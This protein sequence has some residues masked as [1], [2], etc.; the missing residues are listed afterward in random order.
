MVSRR[1]Q[2]V[3]MVVI[4]LVVFGITSM[5]PLEPPLPSPTL[6]Y[7]TPFPLSISSSYA[8]RSAKSS[9]RYD[10]KEVLPSRS[11]ITSLQ[12]RFPLPTVDDFLASLHV[13]VPETIAAE[14]ETQEEETNVEAPPSNDP[15]SDEIREYTIQNFDFRRKNASLFQLQHV[16]ST[17]WTSITHIPDLQI[18]HLWVL[19]LAGVSRK[20]SAGGMSILSAYTI[21]DAP[22]L[23]R[24]PHSGHV[25]WHKY[26][27]DEVHGILDRVTESNDGRHIFLVFH[28][29]TEDFHNREYFLRVYYL[30]SLYAQYLAQEEHKVLEH[31]QF[32]SAWHRDIVKAD[33]EYRRA[34]REYE[35]DPHNKEMPKER[36]VPRPTKMPSS[37]WPE[38]VVSFDA[39]PCW[40]LDADQQDWAVP[41]CFEIPLVGTLPIYSMEYDSL[42]QCLFYSRLED[43]KTFRTICINFFDNATQPVPEWHTKPDPVIRVRYMTE[44]GPHFDQIQTKTTPLMFHPFQRYS[45]DPGVISL[46]KAH[47]G[48][49][50]QVDLRTRRRFDVTVYSE[51]DILQALDDAMIWGPDG[52]AGFAEVDVRAAALKRKRERE[53]TSANVGLPLKRKNGTPQ[54]EKKEQGCMETGRQLNTGVEASVGDVGTTEHQNTDAA[55][56]VEKDE[57]ASQGTKEEKVPCTELTEA[58][59]NSRAEMLQYLRKENKARAKPEFW[60]EGQVLAQLLFGG[61]MEGPGPIRQVS[62]QSI[63]REQIGI[64]YFKRHLVLVDLPTLMNASAP[65]RDRDSAV[66]IINLPNPYYEEMSFWAALA[67]NE[68]EELQVPSS[69]FDYQTVFWDADGTK[70]IAIHGNRAFM[71]LRRNLEDYENAWMLDSTMDFE[72]QLPRWGMD[73]ELGLAPSND[74]RLFPLTGTFVERGNKQFC[75][76]LYSGGVVGSYDA[77]YTPG[78]IEEIFYN[79]LDFN[80]SVLTCVALCLLLCVLKRTRERRIATNTATA[81]AAAQQEDL[82]PADQTQ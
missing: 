73:M 69:F 25:G 42:S 39:D 17:L 41:N 62:R 67:G 13:P 5:E 34:L 43:M 11:L 53:R 20:W 14:T 56:G 2:V 52:F 77:S 33:K 9:Q 76:V 38:G 75:I 40:S 63:Y 80:L 66:D 45:A 18:F 54:T 68:L 57:T 19:N 29:T 10:S 22:F 6:I 50:L 35:A 82:M 27:E 4:T 48:L 55:D 71:L 12:N 21:P 81:E 37:Q 78:S 47:E 44:I 59:I 15:P 64:T 7:H 30:E 49:A 24:E 36:E 79:S 72:D 31:Q 1:V 74:H 70:L 32:E 16:N 58:D 65:K 61:N 46:R 26:F 23:E 60:R 3:V 51:E 8:Q 28:E